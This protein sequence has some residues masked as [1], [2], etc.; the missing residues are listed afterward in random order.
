M[1]AWDPGSQRSRP[2]ML[3]V[4]SVSNGRCWP[5][6]NDIRKVVLSEPTSQAD[7]T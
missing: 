6:A 7:T 2:L 3:A 1:A 5:E 4:V